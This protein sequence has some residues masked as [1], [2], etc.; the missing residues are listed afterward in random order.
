[1]NES[2]SLPSQLMSHPVCAGR[3]GHSVQGQPQ[4]SVHLY[5]LPAR[6]Q[7]PP[8]PARVATPAAVQPEAGHQHGPSCAIQPHPG[9]QGPPPSDRGCVGHLHLGGPGQAG[10][11]RGALGKQG[12]GPTPACSLTNTLDPRHIADLRDLGCGRLGWRKMCQK[13]PCGPS[14]H[15][16]LCP[17][18]PSPRKPPP[19]HFPTAGPQPKHQSLP[20][21][22]VVT[23]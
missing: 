23:D 4:A 20:R 16:F 3:V 9:T 1:M 7:Y 19:C 17:S 18:R 10:Y 13:S 14:F 8:S 11:V 21:F 22:P 6:C 5:D 12:P 2:W 15:Q